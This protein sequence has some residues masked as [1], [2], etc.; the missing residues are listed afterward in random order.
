[1]QINGI[2]REVSH[3]EWGFAAE[4]QTLVSAAF[5]GT[6]VNSALLDAALTGHWKPFYDV[7]SKKKGT[8]KGA[9]IQ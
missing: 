3:K 5:G 7:Q 4:Q 9:L 8:I 2:T 6:C 1:L